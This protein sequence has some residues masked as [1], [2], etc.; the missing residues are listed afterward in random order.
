MRNIFVTHFEILQLILVLI[1]SF[2]QIMIP[3]GL[4]LISHE[5]RMHRQP[6]VGHVPRYYVQK[7]VCLFECSR[8]AF[9][10]F[11]YSVKRVNGSEVLR[12]VK[13][14]ILF[15]LLFHYLVQGHYSH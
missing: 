7:D 6:K 15:D 8:H 10:F 3:N 5:N 14:L 11:N 2:F 4:S 1:V 13:C 9:V 12:V